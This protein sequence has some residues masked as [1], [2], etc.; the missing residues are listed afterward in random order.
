MTYG[1]GKWDSNSVTLLFS[2]CVCVC[3]CVCV[4]MCVQM[5]ILLHLLVCKLFPERSIS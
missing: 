1:L 3:V 2:L 5:E 4:C